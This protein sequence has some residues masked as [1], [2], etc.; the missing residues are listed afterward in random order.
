MVRAIQGGGKFGHLPRC[1]VKAYVHK[2]ETG[3]SNG[4]N[5]IQ[6]EMALFQYKKQF[7]PSLDK[8][9]IRHIKARFHA[10]C[11]YTYLKMRKFVPFLREIICAFFISP[12]SGITFLWNR[13]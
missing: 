12:I 13:G 10:V 8:G 11:A 3:L 6:G 1:D 9:S 4:M 7:F 2:G 5:R